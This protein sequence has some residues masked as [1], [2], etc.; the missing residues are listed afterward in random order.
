MGANPCLRCGA[1]CARYRVSFYW[2]EA[3]DVTPGGVPVGLTDDLSDFRRA[4]KGTGQAQPRCVVLQGIIGA[5][6]SCSI[7]D[8]RPTVC[9]AF[10]A[11][12][13]DGATPNERC[14]EARA[15]HGLPPLRPDDW[16]EP[17]DHEPTEPTKPIVPLQPAA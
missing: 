12:Y 15:A 8:C 3:D 14:D 7:Y 16:A 6:V 2:G 9:R 13:R 1:C 5:C 4:M 17:D 11:S 10:E